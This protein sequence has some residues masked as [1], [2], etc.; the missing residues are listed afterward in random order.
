[1]TLNN[2]FLRKL[3]K[4]FQL[5][6]TAVIICDSACAVHLCFA[7]SSRIPVG[8]WP[9]MGKVRDG[10]RTSSGCIKRRTPPENVRLVGPREVF[11]VST[12]VYPPTHPNSVGPIRKTFCN[13]EGC[14]W[15]PRHFR[16]QHF[17]KCTALRNAFIA[18]GWS[19]L[20]CTCF[21]HIARIAEGL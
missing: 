20:Q 21:I 10:P 15:K 14:C 9:Q 5:R 12:A 17:R 6:I 3:A 13:Q 7:M 11:S 19:F 16:L 18:R 1:M 8:R 2:V 4:S